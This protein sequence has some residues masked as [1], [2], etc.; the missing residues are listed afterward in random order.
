M[1]CLVL[2]WT[3]SPAVLTVLSFF[4]IGFAWLWI[5]PPAGGVDEVSH[6]VRTVGLAHGQLIGDDV[7]PTR[8]LAHLNEQQLLRVNAEAGWFRIPGRSPSPSECNVLDAT[9]PFDCDQTPEVP[10]TIEEVSLHGRSL[11]GAYVVPAGFAR[12][13][14]GM[15]STLMLARFGMLVQNTVLFAVIV[16]ALQ[17]IHRRGSGLGQS[18]IVV[19]ALTATPVLLFLAGT[20]SPSAT[21]ILAVGA[22]TATLIADARTHTRS[23][24]WLAAF[25]AVIASWARDLGGPAVLL[26]TLS[27][28]AVEPGLRRWFMN[29]GIK[30]WIPVGIAAVGIATSQIWQMAYKHPLSPEFGSLAR[31]WG[32]TMLTVTTLRDAVGLGGWLNTRMDPLL[33]TAWVLAWVLLFATLVRRVS[34]VVRRVIMCQV[35]VLLLVSVLL[36]GSLRAG[37]FGTQGRFLLP[38]IAI[39][40]IILATASSETSVGREGLTR[41]AVAG[42]S[43]FVALGH[44]SALVIA[45]HRHARGLNGSSIDFSQAD[46]SPP[47]GW[48]PAG[49]LMVLAVGCLCAGAIAGWGIQPSVRR[50]TE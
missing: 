23:F 30:R 45:A 21:E 32:D 26:A 22:F 2:R 13:G 11:P 25:L 6:Y 3:E 10:G 31:V 46:W 34:P 9:R 29:A 15:W 1:K 4:L 8:P 42:V 39:S 41:S 20:M 12:F 49:I 40:V 7:D 33:E 48:V 43:L 14:G 44:V 27:I 18:A 37:G 50:M 19:L 16:W 38:F 28:A 35:I 5:T 47:G 36:I 24:I 17:A